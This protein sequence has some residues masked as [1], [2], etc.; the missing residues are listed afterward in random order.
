MKA[1]MVAYLWRHGSLIEH[2]EEGPWMTYSENLLSTTGGILLAVPN[3]VIMVNIELAPL[4]IELAPPD[5]RTARQIDAAYM[6][7]IYLPEVPS[8]LSQG[9][10][11]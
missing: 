8:L 11:D 3:A 2:S 9:R 4:K 7:L 1:V 6:R 5:Y 10:G